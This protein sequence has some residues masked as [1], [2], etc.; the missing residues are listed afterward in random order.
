MRPLGCSA[1][2]ALKAFST[3][4]AVRALL[5]LDS[6]ARASCQM[7]PQTSLSTAIS[8]GHSLRQGAHACQLPAGMDR[9]NH[10]M[11][12]QTEDNIKVASDLLAW[13]QFMRETCLQDTGAADLCV[14]NTPAQARQGQK[15]S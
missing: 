7:H 1:H 3:A 6:P 4:L 14:R 11:R 12:L 10:V 2:A 9:Y 15:Q 8:L 5:S 13:A